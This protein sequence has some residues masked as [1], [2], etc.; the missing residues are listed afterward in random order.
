MPAVFL[1]H[2]ALFWRPPSLLTGFPE[3]EFP[4]FLRYYEDAKTS[5]PSQHRSRLSRPALPAL[6]DLCSLASPAVPELR[7][8]VVARFIHPGS[9]QRPRSGSPVFPSN[10]L[11]SCPVLRPRRNLHAKPFQRFDV[12]LP[13]LHEKGFRD[14][15]FRDS[16]ARPLHSL[17]TLRAGVTTDYATLASGWRLPLA[18]SPSQVTGFIQSISLPFDTSLDYGLFTARGD[19]III[20]RVGKIKH[21]LRGQG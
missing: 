4:G 15:S 16:I 11:R 10:P 20:Q 13:C 8:D 17:C 6:D 3:S 7:L 9:V 12:A 19:V 5:R 18:G 2:D 14:Q 1:M 21:A